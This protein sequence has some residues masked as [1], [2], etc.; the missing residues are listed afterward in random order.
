GTRPRDDLERDYRRQFNEAI[1]ARPSRGRHANALLHVLGPLTA[2]LD[3]SQRNE[4]VAAIDL[5]HQ[6]PAPNSSPM[7]LPRHHA[8]A[9]GHTSLAQQSYL[10]PYPAEL[11]DL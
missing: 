3:P 8:E 1:A 6:D 2:L 10:D 7:T 4:S 5:H 9:T 11:R